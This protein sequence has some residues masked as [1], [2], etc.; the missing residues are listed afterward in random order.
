MATGGGAAGSRRAVRAG[1]GVRGS[2][3]FWGDL[4]GTGGLERGGW[5]GEARGRSR[6]VR[7][8]P[9]RE[10]G[11]LRSGHWSGG[12]GRLWGYNGS[13]DGG[14]G[15]TWGHRGMERG[16]SGEVG[17]W[18]LPMGSGPVPVP[19]VPP[20]YAP[21]VSPDHPNDLY[22]PHVSSHRQDPPRSV[23]HGSLH[24]RPPRSHRVPPRRSPVPPPTPFCARDPPR[25]QRG[26]GRS[27]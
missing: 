20:R 18:G 2:G 17:V 4:G 12:N 3:E 16:G 10:A 26:A 5:D 6:K 23:A 7:E 13:T 22:V 15:E 19:Q 24:P 11:A 21:R 27:R 25:G 14:N 1:G 9:G 8:H